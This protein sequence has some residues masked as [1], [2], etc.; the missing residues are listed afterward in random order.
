[1][2]R[3]IEELRYKQ[4][5]PLEIKVRMTKNRIREWVKEY[6]T[7][8]CY[9]SFS[10]GKDST[11]LLHIVREMYPTI[12]AVFI[13][14]GLEYPEIREFVRTF[15]N[16]EWVKP[17]MNFKQVIDRYGYPF[18]SKELSG[19]IGG[20][21]RS[22]EILKEEGYDISDHKVVIEECAKRKGAKSKGEW[23]RLAQCMG[24]VTNKNEIKSDLEENEKGFFSDIPQKYKFLLNA[25]FDLSDVCCKVMKKA[26]AHDY[27][28]QTGRTPITGQMAEESRMRT[29]K[30]LK[31]G[32]NAFEQLHPHSNPMAFWTE[33]DVL[34]YIKNNNIQIASVYGDVVYEDDGG[35]QY[36]EVIDDSGVMMT[37]TGCKRTGCMFCGY[38]CQMEKG[39]GRF[40]LM[41]ETHPKQYEYIMKP[42]KDG[43]LNY[44][45]I[46]DWMNENGNLGI[47]Y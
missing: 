46:I 16:V 29:G 3:T 42:W 26:P 33:Q 20:G 35:N 30:W 43:G 39:K 36:A 15:D 4:N 11:V 1:M 37:T 32:C 12:P 41:K 38:G 44:K 2:E 9:V 19:I 23:R 6:G 21:Q 22:L 18:I 40:E 24:A 8:G 25:P 14:T 34:K 45:E 31:Y 27:E 28:K 10:G 47:K 7:G 13:D 5:L 17:K